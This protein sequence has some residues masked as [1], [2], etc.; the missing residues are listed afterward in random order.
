[1]HEAG[2]QGVNHITFSV[3][4]LDRS[5]MFYTDIVG[6]TAIVR[7][8]GGAYLRIGDNWIC[9]SLDSQTREDPLAEYS[10][11]AFSLPEA[12]FQEKAN[13]LNHYGIPLWKDNRSE[14]DSLYFLDPDGHKLEFHCGDLASRLRALRGRPYPGMRWL[15]DDP[16]GDLF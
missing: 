4:D 16:Q 8:D 9:L 7:W 13:R 2:G 15:L 14:G 5:L 11:I 6:M 1:M 12:A 10:H 3:S